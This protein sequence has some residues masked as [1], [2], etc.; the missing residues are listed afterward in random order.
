[1][2][3]NWRLFSFENSVGVL[4]LYLQKTPA[5]LI[6]C[7]DANSRLLSLRHSIEVVAL[8]QLPCASLFSR[9]LCS[10]VISSNKFI[11]PSNFLSNFSESFA[12]CCYVCFLR[13]LN[14][15][16]QLLSWIILFVSSVPSIS[17]KRYL[18]SEMTKKV[19]KHFKS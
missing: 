8:L 13:L 1:M 16:F 15:S 9:Y 6:W 17:Y 19:L 14:L 12:P 18:N 5:F 3:L 2:D 4:A 11:K 10:K 7:L